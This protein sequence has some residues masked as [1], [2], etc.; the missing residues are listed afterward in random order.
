M[1]CAFRARLKKD[2]TNS[3]KQYRAESK[4]RKYTCIGEDQQS[5]ERTDKIVKAGKTEES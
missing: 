4:D 3:K 2:A 5:E 1:L